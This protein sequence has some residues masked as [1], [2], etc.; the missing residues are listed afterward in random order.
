M[1]RTFLA[2]IVGAGLA[3]VAGSAVAGGQQ[4]EATQPTP[5]E[6]QKHAMQNGPSTARIG[7]LTQ[8]DPPA[9]QRPVA[10]V[11]PKLLEPLTQREVGML[12][13]AC[14]AY[15]EC[16]AAYSKAYEHDQALRRARQTAADA[17]Q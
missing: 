2:I 5:A 15:A 8:K 9:K 12:Y 4:A 11:D 16:W 3:V 13:H 1:Q 7:Y 6:V 17:D 14:I 10:P